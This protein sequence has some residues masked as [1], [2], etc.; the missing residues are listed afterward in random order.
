LEYVHD[1]QTR[2]NIAHEIAKKNLKRKTQYQN[3][4]YYAKSRIKKNSIRQP[5]LL[6]DQT[7]KAGKYYLNKYCFLIYLLLFDPFWKI[8]THIG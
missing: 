2:I 5:V 3:R 4:Y 1:M 7:M 6:P 8:L